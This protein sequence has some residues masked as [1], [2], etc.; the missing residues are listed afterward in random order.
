MNSTQYRYDVRHTVFEVDTTPYD[1]RLTGFDKN[2]TVSEVHTTTAV[3]VYGQKKGPYVRHTAFAKKCVVPNHYR[4]PLLSVR[5]T[6]PTVLLFLSNPYD[7]IN[8]ST[9][10]PVYN[11]HLGTQNLWPMLTD[12]R[13][14]DVTLRMLEK[15]ISGP[16]NSG[17]CRLVV[18][19]WRWSFTQV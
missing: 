13:C 18:V 15:L 14:S 12:G 3:Y 16:Q 2:C 11:D 1:I 17:R 5:R 19:I 7:F 9:V 8:I 4:P 6:R 10:K